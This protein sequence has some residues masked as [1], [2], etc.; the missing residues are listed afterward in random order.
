MKG[1]D[2]LKETFKTHR[3]L[4]VKADMGTGKSEAFCRHIT[5]T[6]KPFVILTSRVSLAR[7]IYRRVI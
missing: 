3:A 5:S 2:V 6:N 4:V 7:D 1:D